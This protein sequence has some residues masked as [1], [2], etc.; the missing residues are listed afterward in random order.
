MEAKD[1]VGEGKRADT[2][3]D[4]RELLSGE[5]GGIVFSTIEKFRL[6]DTETGKEEFHPVLSLRENIV[7]I[8][9]ECHRTQYGL[10]EGFAHNLRNALPNAS[11]I[12]FTERLSIVKM[13]IQYRFLVK[14]FTPTI[15]NRQPMTKQS[16]LSFMN[17]GWQNCTWPMN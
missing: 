11:F 5:G 3:D 14:L 16:F 6:K 8:A 1:L 17:P 10:I 7:V 15:S 2:A 9:D 13:L 12:G 4:L